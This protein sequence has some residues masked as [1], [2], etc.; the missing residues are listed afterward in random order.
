[1]KNAF[2]DTVK[3]LW[4]NQSKANWEKLRRALKTG[5]VKYY[6]VAFEKGKLNKTQDLTKSYAELYDAK[7][8]PVGR[9]PIFIKE[10]KG[11]RGAT[12]Y[13]TGLLNT[14]RAIE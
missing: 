1:M 2:D 9:V 12:I 10:G 11:V 7:E 5:G 13:L 4:K 3:A 6:A 8:R 14:R